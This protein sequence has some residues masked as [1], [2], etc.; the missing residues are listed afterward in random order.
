[1]PSS[2]GAAE[3]ARPWAISRS[4]ALQ[5]AGGPLNLTLT[6]ETPGAGLLAPSLA[7]QACSLHGRGLAGCF[8]PKVRHNCG[9]VMRTAISAAVPGPATWMA[10]RAIGNR[11]PGAYGTSPK[12]K[13]GAG[14]A[15]GAGTTAAAAPDNHCRHGLEDLFRCQRA[16]PP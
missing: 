10:S 15:G 8:W 2:C 4:M 9:G 16:A 13:P 7:W 14:P 3:S 12:T 5:P 11:A 1:M 6:N